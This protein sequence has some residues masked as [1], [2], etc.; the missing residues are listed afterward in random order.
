[1]KTFFTRLANDESGIT[2]IEYG[3]L[4]AAI[5]A[6]IATLVGDSA[7]DGTLL[8]ALSTKFGNILS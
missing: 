2:A 7:T 6:G 4:A 5:A 8:N 3:V 1:M